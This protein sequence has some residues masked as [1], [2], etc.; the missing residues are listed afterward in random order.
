MKK[1]FFLIRKS[2]VL[3]IFTCNARYIFQKVKIKILQL[4]STIAVISFLSLG[5]V[6]FFAVRFWSLQIKVKK[7][8]ISCTYLD[9]W[10]NTFAPKVQIHIILMGMKTSKEPVKICTH[11]ERTKMSIWYKNKGC[12]LF[13]YPFMKKFDIVWTE[14]FSMNFQLHKHYNPWYCTFINMSFLNC[15]K[16]SLAYTR[17]D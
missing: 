1:G 5:N 16:C 3:A 13:L 4:C 15:W 8:H 7:L 17:I 9:T 10:Y 12:C 2:H 14:G 6:V 11:D